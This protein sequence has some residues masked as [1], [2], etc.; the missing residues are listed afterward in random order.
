[1]LDG[2]HGDDAAA[3]V[4]KDAEGLQAGHPAGEDRPGPQGL[5]KVVH[6]LLLG[7]PA[8]ETGHWGTFFIGEHLLDCKAGRLADP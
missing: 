1:M 3:H 7:R 2:Q 4:Q 8:A 6:G 5:Q